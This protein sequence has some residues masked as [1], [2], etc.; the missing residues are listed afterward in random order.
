MRA[1]GFSAGLSTSSTR[2]DDLVGRRRVAQR[3]DELLA[4]Q[5]AGQAGQQLHVFGAAGFGRRDQERQ[6][7]RAVGC[8]EVDGGLEPR[9]PDRGGVDVR[10]PAVRDRDA[11]RQPGGRLF[12]AGHR[13]GGQSVGIG[14]APGV[15]EP[16]DEASD[17]GLL[18][19]ARVDVE[20]HQIGIDDGPGSCAGH[21]DTFG[22]LLRTGG[23][24]EEGID[25]IDVTR[26]ASRSTS[27]G[28]GSAE[29][30]SAA[31][32]LP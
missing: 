31:A 8:A 30:G 14:C 27:A 22:W 29:P 28:V 26:T 1:F 2:R 15:G 7:R 13:G 18:V 20:E 17:H 21:G 10:R 6:I 3:L 23:V 5:G 12:L 25:E 4:H 9:E 32:A 19:G 24:G 16:A 11:A